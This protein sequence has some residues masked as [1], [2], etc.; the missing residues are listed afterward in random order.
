M[1]DKIITVKYGL[2]DA[3]NISLNNIF[4][5]NVSFSGFGFNQ[6]KQF[7]AFLAGMFGADKIILEGVAPDGS[8]SSVMIDCKVDEFSNEEIEDCN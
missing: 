7:S 4:G 1:E 3:G 8:G 2:E 6:V 5:S